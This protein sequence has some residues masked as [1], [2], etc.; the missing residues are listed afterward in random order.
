MPLLN[1]LLLP[2]HVAQPNITQV[3]IVPYLSMHLLEP[4]GTHAFESDRY[5]EPLYYIYVI[6]SHEVC[7]WHIIY[8]T[9]NK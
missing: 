6:A 4:H 8:G 9:C 2:I 1:S 3:V 5:L 7:V